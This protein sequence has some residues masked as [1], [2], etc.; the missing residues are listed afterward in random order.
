MRVDY[1]L[2]MRVALGPLMWRDRRTGTWE[3]ARVRTHRDEYAAADILI[4]DVI[5]ALGRRQYDG[6]SLAELKAVTDRL[7]IEAMAARATTIRPAA[8]ETR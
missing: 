5:A 6:M 8:E 7:A 2:I 1:H 3:I 4:D